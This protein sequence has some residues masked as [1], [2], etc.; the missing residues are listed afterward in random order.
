M[1]FIDYYLCDACEKKAFYDATLN[2]DF[3]KQV[4][5]G[6]GYKLGYVGDMIVICDDC[7]TKHE[8]VLMP[9]AALKEAT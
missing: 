2:Y 5:Y 4:G 9:R 3:N 7:A 8:V 1:A 6:C